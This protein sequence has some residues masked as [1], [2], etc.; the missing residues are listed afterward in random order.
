MSPFEITS[1]LT[2]LPNLEVYD[3][4]EHLP[5]N[6]NSSYHTPQDLS[7]LD[8]SAND[9]LLF[10]TNIRSLSLHFDELVS[11]LSTLKISF[12]VIG[13]SETWNSFDV[14]TKTNV[15]IP[16]YSYFHSQSHT[17]NG[18]VALYVKS[19][20]TPIPRPD[21]SKDST[22]FESVWVEVENKQ[23]KNYLFS[24]IYRHPTLS[25]DTFNEYL[26]ETLSNPAV[27][28]KHVFILGDFNINLFNY[29]S[30]TPIT[31]YVNFLFSQQFLPYI[32]HPSRVSAHSSTLI[33][34][35]FSNITDNETLSGNILTKITDHFP[36]FLIVKHAGITYKNLS[37][38][39]HD[40]SRFNE[41]NVQNDFANLDLSYLNDNALDVNAQFN[42]LLSN[43]DEVVKTHAPL[44]KLTK[45]DIKFRNKPW[46]NGKIQKMM[47]IRDR[48]LKKLKKNNNPALTSLY[49]KFRN[50]VSVSLNESKA[51]YFYD[52]FQ[53]NSNNMKQL[54]SGIKS[55]IDV[56]RSSNINVISKLKDS[57]GN[58]TSDPVVIANIFNKFFVNVS[59]DI[60][61]N[62]PRSNKS[63][64]NFM[65]DTIGNSFFTA[66][67]VPFE[68]SDI[69][70]A[71][72][73][74]KSLGP[75]SIPMKVPMNFF[76][77]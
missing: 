13:V 7:T 21:L 54:W 40:F 60:T 50:R 48:I 11:T 19:G 32:I 18:G 77:H 73:S 58:T 42:R 24:C 47:R 4:D 43:L 53:K 16:G 71:L 46:I 38:F 41:V 49:K 44:R 15:E 56:R 28:N 52:Y 62:I 29:N 17:Q 57:S 76:L 64:V 65:G 72:K 1:G 20:L 23:G 63:P 14:P 2:N 67:S 33:D 35:I 39:Q 8:T 34:N 59:H 55:V 12:D 27:F 66:P 3:I 26:Q 70:S 22:D 74:G 68:I 75:N 31:N 30:S 36:Q 9:L 45:R 51:S 69:I 10:H 25:F 61:K 37:Y 5:S 6:V